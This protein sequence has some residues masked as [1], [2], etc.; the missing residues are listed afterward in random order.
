MSFHPGVVL[1]P[2]CLLQ[3]G[4]TE[5]NSLFSVG[6][7]ETSR[8]FSAFLF[9]WL[10][11]F[12][13]AEVFFF[14]ARRWIIYLSSPS[15][16]KST[17]R[18]TPPL[19]RRFAP[20]ERRSQSLEGS[21]TVLS[22]VGWQFQASADSFSRQSFSLLPREMERRR[23]QRV[24]SPPPAAPR[25]FSEHPGLVLCSGLLCFYNLLTFSDSPADL[26]LI[27]RLLTRW[28][29]K[30]L[31]KSVSLFTPVCSAAVRSLRSLPE[32][33]SAGLSRSLNL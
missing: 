6:F 13:H 25:V 4:R 21:L 15:L 11:F 28:S 8:S 3:S 20:S 29:N 9:Y 33:L 24:C 31:F 23:H 18:L 1:T 7:T 2:S 26:Q 12:C 22:G 17:V 19:R 32:Q 10:F 30:L 16:I 14:F 5:E 27:C